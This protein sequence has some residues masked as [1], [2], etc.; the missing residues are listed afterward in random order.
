MIHQQKYNSNYIGIVIQNNDP[1]GKGRIKVYVPHVSP[2]VYKRWNELSEDKKFKFLG[3][4]IDSD[5]SNCTRIER[6]ITLV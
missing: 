4:N 6:N 3:K 5:L 2:T 1:K